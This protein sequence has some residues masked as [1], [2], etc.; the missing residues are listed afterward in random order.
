[1]HRS[2]TS[3]LGG[4]LEVLGLSIGKAVMP[5]NPEA[6]NPKGFYENLTIMDLHDKFLKS[7]HSTWWDYRPVPAKRFRSAAARQFREELLQALVAEFGSD[8]PMIKDPRMCRLMPLWIPLIKDYFPAARFVLP[9]RHPLEV[10]WS[11]RKRDQFELGLGLKLWAVHVLE[12][13]VFTRTFRRFFTTYDELLQSPDGTV[14]RLAT[15][16]N[17]STEAVGATVFDQVDGTLR[18]HKDL[19]WPNGEP[20][21][22]L[23]LSIHQALLSKDFD[24]EEKLDDLRKA[25]YHKC[26]DGKN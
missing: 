3:A 20:D 17:L 16:M 12:G 1:M 19:V 5:Q 14:S 13:E 21:K 6:G 23:F 9:I 26:I 7:V 24:R 10:A 25:Y 2:G 8:R 4:A 22:D 18:H 11:L 15:G